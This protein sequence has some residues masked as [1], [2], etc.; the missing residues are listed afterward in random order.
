MLEQ[1]LSRLPTRRQVLF[2]A[3]LLLIVV[4]LVFLLF[5]QQVVR[6][7]RV[8]L[9]FT[10]VGQVSL[11]LP[12][13]FVANSYAAGLHRPRFM[14]VGPDGT[15]FVA[16]SQAGRVIA[17]PDTDGNGVADKTIIV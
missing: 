15:L 9:D 17:L 3:I 1:R 13:G 8:A 5:Q 6:R 2:L 4:V 14:A 7:L 10:P 11:Q 12:P 16:E